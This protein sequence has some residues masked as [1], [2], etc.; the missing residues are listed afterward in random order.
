MGGKYRGLVTFSKVL[1]VVAILVVVVGILSSFWFSL[2][3]G[4]SVAGS[5]AFGWTSV[6]IILG[7]CGSLLTGVLIY[8]FGE[9]IKL[10]IDIETEIGDKVRGKE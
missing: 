9:V 4:G 8:S 6:F 7:I 3:W 1:R 2:F 5:G 10:L